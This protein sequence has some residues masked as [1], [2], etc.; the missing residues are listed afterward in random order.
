V[1]VVVVVVVRVSRMRESS[2]VV[3]RRGYRGRRLGRA[4]R[5]NDGA[6]SHRANI[7]VAVVVAVV[8]RRARARRHHRSNARALSLFRGMSVRALSRVDSRSFEITDGRTNE[9]TERRRRKKKRA[10]RATTSTS[11]RRPRV[12][13]V[14]CGPVVVAILRTRKSREKAR[15]G[16]SVGHETWRDSV[17]GHESR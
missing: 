2:I 8:S 6:I 5:R 15:G 11:A 3:S 7:V 13:V 14:V 17:T 16:R 4:E 9:R 1:V 10:A 12:V